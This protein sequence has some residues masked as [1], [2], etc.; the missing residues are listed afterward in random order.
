MNTNYYYVIPVTDINAS[1]GNGPTGI[2]NPVANTAQTS[3]GLTAM[4]QFLHHFPNLFEIKSDGLGAVVR[5]LELPREEGSGFLG[6]LKS[7]HLLS[8]QASA[9]SPDQ[10]GRKVGLKFSLLP[11]KGGR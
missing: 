5:A 2:P 9:Q 1:L 4:L 7:R 8:N 10:K 3:F 11:G 6:G